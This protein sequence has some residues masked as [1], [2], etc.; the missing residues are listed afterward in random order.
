MSTTDKT[1]DIG[2][3]I[4]LSSKLKP[5]LSYRKTSY[6]SFMALMFYRTGVIAGLSFILLE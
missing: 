3:H 5:E 2:I 1:R 4:Q 6:T